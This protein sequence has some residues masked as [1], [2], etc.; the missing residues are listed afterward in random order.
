MW[1]MAMTG[2]RWDKKRTRAREPRGPHWPA[3][4]TALHPFV[5]STARLILARLLAIWPSV[6]TAA[7]NGCPGP[8]AVPNHL[9]SPPFDPNVC[10]QSSSRWHQGGEAGRLVG[11]NLFTGPAWIEPDFG[12]MRPSSVAPLPPC[13]PSLTLPP[14]AS[15]PRLPLSGASTWLSRQG[16]GA[17]RGWTLWVGVGSQVARVV[18]RPRLERP[19]S[20]EDY[21]ELGD[22]GPIDR[23]GF[24]LRN[25]VTIA[26]E[27]G[28]N[29]WVV[30]ATPGKSVSR[31]AYANF[32]DGVLFPLPQVQQHPAAASIAQQLSVFGTRQTLLAGNWSLEH[33]L[34]KGRRP[35][36]L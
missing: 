22:K 7:G 35:T 2:P 34:H 32:S 6:V 36:C 30:S 17:G 33:N 26:I 11:Q 24:K 10:W 3:F 20:A 13:S 5:F 12:T 4:P 21:A 29:A 19:S 9:V 31:T 23:E 8:A 1:W 27:M 16:V 18:T 14:S 28:A 15:Q 25:H